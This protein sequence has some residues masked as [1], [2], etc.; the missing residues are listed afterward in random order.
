MAERL[1]RMFVSVCALRLKVWIIK[2]PQGNKK[3]LELKE[4]DHGNFRSSS[5]TRSEWML[6]RRLNSNK[7]TAEVKKISAVHPRIAPRCL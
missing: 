5:M 7:E 6:T 1:R 3:E 2:P 4:R